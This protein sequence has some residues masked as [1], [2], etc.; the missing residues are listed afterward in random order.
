MRSKWIM[1]V[2]VCGLALVFAVPTT[3]L[4]ERK[5]IS[6]SWKQQECSNWCWIA[7]AQNSVIASLGKSK[8]QTEGAKYIFGSAKNKAGTAK[9]T[10]KVAEYL[11][12]GVMSYDYTSIGNPK[13]F[14]FLK[15]HIDKG[16][17]PITFAGY[18]TEGVRTSGHATVI[19]G[20][21]RGN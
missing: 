20:Y 2:I 11:S 12:G 14:Y 18:Y 13:G 4:A 17:V 5:Y 1:K 15:S 10:A 8:T 3:V 7:S 16:L 19:V 21:T 9:Q 6:L